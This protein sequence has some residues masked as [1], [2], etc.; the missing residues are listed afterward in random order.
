M[1]VGSVSFS[2]ADQILRPP[3]DGLQ[4]LRGEQLEA[5]TL[6]PG[7][8]A[9]GGGLITALECD[10]TAELVVD[11]SGCS[12]IPGFVDCHTHLPFAGWRE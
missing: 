8:L 11:A 12:L 10:R 3:K 2:G 6:H 4:H 1:S 5:Q 9:V 7:G